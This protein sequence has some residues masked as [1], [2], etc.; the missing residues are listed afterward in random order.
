VLRIRDERGGCRSRFEAD[1]DDIEARG[2]GVH[3]ARDP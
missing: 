1:E 3:S 2:I